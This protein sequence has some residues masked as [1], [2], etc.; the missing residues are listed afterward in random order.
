MKI[1]NLSPRGGLSQANAISRGARII[2]T[3]NDRLTPPASSPGDKAHALARAGIG[4]IPL[5]GAAATELFQI[6]IAP[7]LERRQQAWMEAVAEGLRRLEYAYRRKPL[8]GAM[9]V[10]RMF[11]GEHLGR[12][13]VLRS[14]RLMVTR[15]L[16]LVRV[17]CNCGDFLSRTWSAKDK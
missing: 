4:S 1:T 3:E 16:D 8:R 2:M 17:S 9:A 11:P 10:T 14:T 12:F 7:P 15:L 5:V 6:L 13:G